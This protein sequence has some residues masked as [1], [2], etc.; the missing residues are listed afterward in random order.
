MATWTTIADTTLEPGK[1]VRSIDGIALRDNPIAIAEGAAGAPRIQTAAYADRSIS[2]VKI[3]LGAVDTGE[4]AGSAVGQGQL[5]TSES[6]NSS[7][8]SLI[9]LAVPGGQYSF[10]PR[11]W[12]DS[13]ANT[14]FVRL[15]ES[16]SSSNQSILFS[17]STTITGNVR[18]RFIQSSPPYDLGDGI[19]Q[20]FVY[21]R[22]ND[23]G[24][25]VGVY[26]SE[27]P[28][29]YGTTWG[30]TPEYHMVDGKLHGSWKRRK[31]TARDVKEGRASAAELMDPGNVF[32]EELEITP[33]TK[34]RGIDERPHPWSDSM[35]INHQAILLDPM[36][37]CTGRIVRAM[38]DGD[39]P[40][41]LIYSGHIKIDNTELK[42][43]CPP[44][45]KAYTA[46]LK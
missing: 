1:P 37:E 15:G 13:T 5:K 28:A 16:T 20:G 9:T 14:D 18:S 7:S 43:A 33:Q 25:P 2:T 29:S 31:I 19:V 39:S 24:A 42:R 8:G 30:G 34:L 10:W 46:K 26:I 27:D 45:M 6:T 17:G 22:L 4:I 36:C 44:G 11:Y 40:D 35:P 41:D 21:V 3:Q 12:V 23:S 38:L 32:T